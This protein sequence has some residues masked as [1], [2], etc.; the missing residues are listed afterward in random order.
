MNII[1]KNNNTWIIE[2]DGVRCFLLQ[3][4]DKA[5]LID[6]GM[7]IENIKEVVEG[8]S[9][10]EIILLN[11][12]A[13]RD[14]VAGNSQ[15]DTVHI[16]I[17]ELA[18]YCKSNTIN[19]VVCLFEGDIID[20]GD[21]KLE[22]INI[23]GHTPG[24]IGFYDINNKILISGDPIQKDGRVFMFSEHRNIYAYVASLD[25]LNRRKDDFV[26]IWPSHGVLPLDNNSIEL[27]KKDVEDILNNK[28][29]YSLE[30]RFGTTIRAYK[31]RENIYLVDNK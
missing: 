17:H 31:G 7:N 13:D 16:S 19:N 24:S 9:D 1:T 30:E 11:T 27:C 29:D 8:L 22:V 5:A 4:N 6:T 14:H 28:I 12:H 2:D 20:L 15:F 10:K 23:A 18:F 25:R 3:G 21:R 26:E